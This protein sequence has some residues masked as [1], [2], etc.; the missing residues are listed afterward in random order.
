MLKLQKLK[1]LLT[2]T[3]YGGC[4]PYGPYYAVTQ[5][6]IGDNLKELPKEELKENLTP[7]PKKDVLENLSRIGWMNSES[8]NLA[9]IFGPKK[10]RLKTN[11]LNWCFVKIRSRLQ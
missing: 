4:L 5:F 9:K 6:L 8:K 2:V 3:N 10:S 1:N 7:Y 11:R